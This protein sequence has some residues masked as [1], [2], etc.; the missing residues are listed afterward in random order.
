MFKEKGLI[1][2]AIDFKSINLEVIDL[3]TN[4]SPDMFINNHGITFSKRVLEDL[5]YPQTFSTAWMLPTKFLLSVHARAM[6]QRLLLFLSPNP[7][8]LQL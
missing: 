3:N 2:M 8:R 6:M 4:A 7:N 5:N 1:I